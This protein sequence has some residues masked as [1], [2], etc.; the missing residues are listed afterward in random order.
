[1][2]HPQKG[3][4][5]E[6]GNTFS[7]DARSFRGIHGLD[8][9]P[10][11]SYQEFLNNKQLAKDGA[12]FALSFFPIAGNVAGAIDFVT[13]VSGLQDT[14][15]NDK[16]QRIAMINEMVEEYFKEYPEKCFFFFDLNDLDNLKDVDIAFCDFDM[17]SLDLENFLNNWVRIS[18]NTKDRLMKDKIKKKSNE[19]NKS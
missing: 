3:W 14:F 11:K 6:G 7:S 18:D 9:A 10:C 4:K 15:L 17:F 5:H 2:Q 13:D 19:K 12:L 8:T 1:M 16:E